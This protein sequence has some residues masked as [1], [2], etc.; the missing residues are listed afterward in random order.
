MKLANALVC[1][2][3]LCLSSSAF[4]QAEAYTM[5]CNKIGKQARGYFTVNGQ[6]YSQKVRIGE[7]ASG[8][9]GRCGV[10]CDG[11]PVY[12]QECLNHDVCYAATG[13]L[14]GE[15]GDEFNAAADGFFNGPNCY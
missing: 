12:T 1:A 6:T 7:Q 14:T 2:A 8:C 9:W 3:V 10:A 11:P 5:I 13:Q 4:A 15:C